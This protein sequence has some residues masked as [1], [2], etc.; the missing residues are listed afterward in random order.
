[1][2]VWVC[3]LGWG[4]WGAAWVTCPAC[5][6]GGVTSV[7][8]GSE[9]NTKERRGAEKGGFPSP[10]SVYVSYCDMC[11][12]FVSVISL[13][14]AVGSATHTHTHAPSPHSFIFNVFT[15]SAV[16]CHGDEIQIGIRNCNSWWS[17][18]RIYCLRY[19]SVCDLCTVSDIVKVADDDPDKK[20]DQ[21]IDT[22]SG[23][24]SVRWGSLRR[25]DQYQHLCG[26]SSG[27]MLC[28]LQS[29]HN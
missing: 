6:R 20:T 15:V 25:S 4:G 9:E 29:F 12:C 3:V 11:V 26:D 28:L 19:L 5:Y 22:T 16:K 7:T 10:V 23:F 17:W 18:A 27:C 14:V 1:M 24:I 8:A 2:F 13:N 21:F